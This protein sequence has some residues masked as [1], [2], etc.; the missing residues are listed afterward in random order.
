MDHK[1]E[2]ETW[3]KNNFNNFVKTKVIMSDKKPTRS[4][5]E[6]RITNVHIQIV[7]C[8]DHYQL[9]RDYVILQYTYI[10]MNLY[11]LGV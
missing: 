2:N 8:E 4:Q 10:H 7:K 11:I 6:V 5:N 1:Q 3:T 9:Y